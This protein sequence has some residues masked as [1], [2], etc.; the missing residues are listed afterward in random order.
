LSLEGWRKLPGSL[1]S[2]CLHLNI[3]T[4]V[5]MASPTDD[6]RPAHKANIPGCPTGFLRL[7]QVVGPTGLLPISRATWY[8]GIAAGRF[9]RPIK[10]G[11]ASLWSADSIADLIEELKR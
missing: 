3:L 2:Q 8:A 1:G 6:M 5:E 9:P 7:R 10:I 11:R 4:E